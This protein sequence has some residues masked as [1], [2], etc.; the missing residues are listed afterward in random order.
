MYKKYIAFRVCNLKQIIV[1]KTFQDIF[2]YPN[3]TIQAIKVNAT[4]FLCQV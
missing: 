1:E 2:K 4:L 3:V